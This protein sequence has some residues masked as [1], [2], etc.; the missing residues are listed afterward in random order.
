MA[1]VSCSSYNKDGFY[2]RMDDTPERQRIL[3]PNAARI[4]DTRSTPNQQLAARNIFTF[5]QAVLI[6]QRPAAHNI[7]T[8]CTIQRLAA[9]N[10][11][12][13]LPR[14]LPHPITPA[15]HIYLLGSWMP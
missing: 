5:S 4:T 3:H 2:A 13:T 6:N 8:S 7:F 10:I 12:T 15:A 1:N 11:S 14:L 9:H